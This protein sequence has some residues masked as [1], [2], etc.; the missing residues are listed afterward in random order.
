ML[1]VDKITNNNINIRFASQ[2]SANKKAY[3]FGNEADA[4]RAYRDMNKEVYTDY[5]NGDISLIALIGD[6]FKGLWAILTAQDP[7]LNIKEQ[8]IEE[9]LLNQSQIATNTNLE[10][11]RAF[12]MVA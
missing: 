7:T 11:N 5:A 8:M 9:S 2:T 10:S 4:W 1:T 3:S 12:D 6:K